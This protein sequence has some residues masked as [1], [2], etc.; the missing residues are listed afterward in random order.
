M[1][2]ID[3]VIKIG[4]SE[5]FQEIKGVPTDSTILWKFVNEKI[6]SELRKYSTDHLVNFIKG[7]A[8]IEKELAN[9]GW[10]AGST[11]P[12]V[13]LFKM[14][15]QRKD[16]DDSIKSDLETW[17]LNNRTNPYIPFGRNITIENDKE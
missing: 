13:K 6:I 3:S 9:G 14:F 5:D 15:S 7:L 12:V 11:S 1:N 8:I 4:E 2:I 17:L 10:G 16:I